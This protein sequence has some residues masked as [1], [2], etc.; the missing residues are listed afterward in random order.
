IDSDGTVQKY[1]WDFDGDGTYDWNSTTNG[2]VK[3]KYKD[4]G[5]FTVELKVSDST[6]LANRLFY[7]LAAIDFKVKAKQNGDKVV[8]GWGWGTFH[9]VVIPSSCIKFLSDGDE[10][11]VFDSTGIISSSCPAEFGLISTGSIKYVSSKDSIYVLQC[12]GSIDLCAFNGEAQAGY[13]CGHKMIFMSKSIDNGTFS[14]ISPITVNSESATF[15]DSAVLTIA[16][17]NH[18]GNPPLSKVSSKCSSLRS[19]TALAYIAQGNS[20]YLFNIYRNGQL[21]RASYPSCSYIDDQIAANTPYKYEVYILD[22]AGQQVLFKSDSLCTGSL[23][24]ISPISLNLPPK[25]HFISLRYN[26]A[27]STLAL[28]FGIPND[29]SV[30]GVIYN[31]LGRCEIILFKQYMKAGMYDLILPLNGISQ[32][33]HILVFK[34]GNYQKVKYLSLMR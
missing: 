10:I 33:F 9:T 32:G 12:T 28:R 5:K 23:T 16:G 34:A 19:N 14:E 15:T 11:H 13:V 22:T 1:E 27:H 21:I 30:S 24:H 18:A 3:N 6:G 8:I 4:G 26:R 20:Y 17:F 31:A 2:N 29:E 7:N 25:E